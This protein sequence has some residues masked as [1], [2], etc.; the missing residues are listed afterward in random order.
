MKKAG[1][2]YRLFLLLPGFLL[3]GNSGH[4]WGQNSSVAHPK[5]AIFTL[6]DTA[7][8]DFG[9]LSSGDDH[10]FEWRFR[11]DGTVPLQLKSV[12]C[13][14][15]CCVANWTREAVAPG[16][17]GIIQATYRAGPNLGKMVKHLTVRGN[18]DPNWRRLTLKVLQVPRTFLHPKNQIQPE[19]TVHK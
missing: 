9:E 7:V 14:C 5:I 17:T 15:G 2:T 6:L 10:R 11:N 16:D 3:F 13:H 8:Q 12:N 18:F 4:L 19:K 1:R